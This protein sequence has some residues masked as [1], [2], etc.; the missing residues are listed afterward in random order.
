[1]PTLSDRQTV[2]FR[3]G[4][5]ADWEVVRRLLDLEARGAT[6]RRETSGFR[7]VPADV[8]TQ[9]DVA[10]LRAHREEARRV[11]DYQADDTHLFTDM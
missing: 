3:G 5:S 9:D 10:F 1:M 8:L 11:L 7:V 2:V 6:F 4:F